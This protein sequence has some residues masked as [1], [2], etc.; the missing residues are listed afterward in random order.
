[1]ESTTEIP[2][3]QELEH[4]NEL[5]RNAIVRQEI[6]AQ[7]VNRFLKE[8]RKEDLVA[9]ELLPRAEDPGTL[10]IYCTKAQDGQFSAGVLDQ[11]ETQQFGE[12]ISSSPVINAVIK[13]SRIIHNGGRHPEGARAIHKKIGHCN[14]TKKNGGGYRSR[15]EKYNSAHIGDPV[16]MQ[17]VAEGLIRDIM[18]DH[19]TV[20]VTDE[21][22]EIVSSWGR[23]IQLVVLTH[24]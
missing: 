18:N 20:I 4:L 1:M 15:F 17:T 24:G 13:G 5:E 8:N 9:K 19:G 3:G 21:N 12:W 14:S 22:I 2:I 6:V 10:L 7:R 23:G 16:K 11:I